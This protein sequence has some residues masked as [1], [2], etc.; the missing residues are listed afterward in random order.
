VSFFSP[1]SLQCFSKVSLQGKNGS[2][3]ALNIAVKHGP[4]FAYGEE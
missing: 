1:L 2:G 3:N 4:F